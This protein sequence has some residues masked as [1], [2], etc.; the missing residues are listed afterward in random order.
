MAR[1]GATPIKFGPKPLNRA[2]TPSDRMMCRIHCNSDKFAFLVASMG[3]TDLNFRNFE[4]N[5]F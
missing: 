5:R 1:D 4:K 3:E 2:E